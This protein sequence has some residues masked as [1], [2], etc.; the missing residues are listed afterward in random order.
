MDLKH[1]NLSRH[2]YEISWDVTISDCHLLFFFREYMLWLWYNKNFNCFEK[3]KRH[4]LCEVNC[5]YLFDRYLLGL[6]YKLKMA[7]EVWMWVRMWLDFMIR[8]FKPVLCCLWPT[9]CRF[10]I[11]R[12]EDFT[13]NE[14]LYGWSIKVFVH[15]L[16]RCREMSLAVRDSVCQPTNVNLMLYFVCYVL[17]VLIKRKKTLSFVLYFYIMGLE[18]LSLLDKDIRF[19]T[20]RSKLSR[21]L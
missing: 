13:A 21:T 3:E 17:S 2:V 11:R 4:L 15:G 5:L 10:V 12:R 1:Q 14:Y 20:S 18:T 9:T 16:F 7:V 6:C 8:Y 19:R